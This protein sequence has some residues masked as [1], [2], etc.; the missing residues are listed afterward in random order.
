MIAPM[1]R[2]LLPCLVLLWTAGA[3]D[4]QTPFA[5]LPREVLDVGVPSARVAG[6]PGR[7]AI[8]DTGCR[9][10]SARGL[11]RQLV[12]IAVQEWGYF[13]FPVVDR[14]VPD[15]DDGGPR[16]GPRRP[17]L[18]AAET[19]RIADS[20]AGYWAITP[21]GGWILENQNEVWN[22]RGADE[23]WRYP[24]SAAFISWLMCEGGLGEAAQ[25]RRAIAHHSYIDQAIR[26]RDNGSTTAAYA[27]YDA[28]E[29][30]V[31]PGDLLCTARRPEYER[32]AERRRQLGVGAR[33]HCD[34]VVKVEPQRNR[35]LAIGGNVGDAVS[36]KLLPA[37][38][39]N[40]R[41]RPTVVR[42]EQ[43]VFAHLKLR[44]PS[45]EADALDHTPTIRALGCAG[46][47][48]MPTSFA[49][50]DLVAAGT[51]LCAD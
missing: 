26:A 43:P 36:L 30:D 34:L 10:A 39:T 50:A 19:A 47:A 22:T 48:S 24:W 41:L 42:G 40:G 17:R 20:I 12:D 5:R 9:P 29:V 45:I 8:R 25:F 16:R 33:T 32:L 2:L 46:T 27:A 21:E 28:G 13:G 38:T 14:T 37:V 18:S 7:M 4:A 51:L 35:I 49:T 31:E 15:A 23:D 6:T 3:A 44:A 1:R 11:R